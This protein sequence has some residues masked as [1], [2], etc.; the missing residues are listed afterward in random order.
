MVLGSAEKRTGIVVET[1]LGQE[2]TVVKPLGPYLGHVRGV[3]GATISGDG[4]VRLILDPAAL[5]ETSE[6]AEEAA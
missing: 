2:E 6:T 4:H 3:S 5:V 1:L